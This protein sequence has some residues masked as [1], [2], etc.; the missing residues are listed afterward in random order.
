[1][2]NNISIVFLVSALLSAFFA[3]NAEAVDENPPVCSF[4]ATSG[5]GTA[6]DNRLGEDTNDN[7]ELD[8]GEDLNDNGE[9]DRDTGISSVGL[10][11]GSTNLDLSVDPSFVPGAGV[12]DYT[13]TVSDP[14]QAGT[15]VI[16]ATDGVGITCN[17]TVQIDVPIDPPL[18][19]NVPPNAEAGPAQNT[20]LGQ[21]VNLDG[22]GSNDPDNGPNPL[23]F[24][25]AFAQV[26]L[27]SALTGANITNATSA[28][29]SFTPDVPGDYQ[30]RLDV[31]DG[32]N[33]AS[34]EVVVTVQ[35]T[36]PASREI[37]G[38]LTPD[39][40]T[41]VLTHGLEADVASLWT[42]FS[43]TPG[44]QGAGHILNNRLGQQVNIVQFLWEEGLQGFSPSTYS[45]AFPYTTDAGAVLARLLIERLGPSYQHPIHFIGHSLG[46]VVNAY[47]AQQFLTAT[48]GVTLAQFTILDYPSRTPG[49]TADAPPIPADFFATLLQDLQGLRIENFYSPDPSALGNVTEGPIDDHPQLRHPSDVGGLIFP[50]EPPASDHAGVQQWYRWTMNPNGLTGTTFCEGGTFNQPPSF[51]ASLDPCQGG[52]Q[53]SLFG[54]RPDDSPDPEPPV[55]VISTP[56]DLMNPR[57]AG[58]ELV[59]GEITCPEMASPSSISFD[60]VIPAGASF[61]E[62]DYAF[63]GADEG[64]YGAVHLDDVPAAVSERTGP[65]SVLQGSAA[66]NTVL[67]ASPLAVLSPSSTPSGGDFRGSGLIPLHSPAGR[68]RMMMT[69]TNYPGG[70]AGSIF[71]LRRFSTTS[72]CPARCF[73]KP[74]TICGSRGRDRL[75]GTARRDV[76]VGLQ[77][78][79]TLKGLGG[80]DLICG[81]SGKD[82]LVGG[83]GRDRLDGGVGKDTLDGGRDK[84]IC[85]GGS[86]ADTASRCEKK[87]AV[88]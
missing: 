79:D 56:L 71:R 4:D 6:T 22:S 62:F 38:E 78:N 27:G 75:T 29:A 87:R 20:D 59:N 73:G 85:Q 65:R 10:D 70:R 60:V 8:P 57:P 46:A 14:T 63:S 37:Q 9:L 33:T 3:P 18:P 86:E 51:S 39:R 48:P 47:A 16:I 30:L 83:R 69:M 5:R 15:G 64:D 32:E 26:P 52:W 72:S 66:R 43:A 41:I 24:Q 67:S 21:Q 40:P 11:P 1:M 74:A 25:W 88:P 55:D 12:V 13:V 49:G 61:L 50:A 36:P 68:K 35:P 80:N 2:R 77:G 19:Q 82:T 76:I 84:D 23:T 45:A 58:C 53:G 31:S 44:A 54:P 28:Q 34:D 7:A 42:G 81:G 17:V